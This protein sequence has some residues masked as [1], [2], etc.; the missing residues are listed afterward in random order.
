MKQITSLMRF[1]HY[2]CHE[3]NCSASRGLPSDAEQSSGVT[4]F[5]IST[6]QPLLILFLAYLI[7]TIA[8]RLDFVLFYQ[9]YAEITTFFDQETFGSVPV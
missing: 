6:E 4:E 9:F 1:L 7:L 5:S 2:V 8:F 3:G